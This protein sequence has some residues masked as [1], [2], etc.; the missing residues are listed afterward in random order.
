MIHKVTMLKTQRGVRDGAI[1]PDTFVEG[2]EY[3]IDDALL[4][5]FIELGVVELAGEKS[6]GNAPANKMKAAA[7]ENKSR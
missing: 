4:D 1:H 2:E 7:P 6:K 5:S 3:E